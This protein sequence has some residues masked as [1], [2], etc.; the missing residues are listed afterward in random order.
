VL[1]PNGTLTGS[2]A[3]Q[4][5]RAPELVRQYPDDPRSYFA[6][7][8]ARLRANDGAGAE[9]ALRT[10]LGKDKTL[11][12]YF[13]ETLA[14]RIRG[15]LAGTLMMGGN[16]SAAREA[17]APL[18]ALPAGSPLLDTYSKQLRPTMCN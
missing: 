10:A 18:C 9:E 6:L 2:V 15:T 16:R 5:V 14:N 12:L 3:N 1:M 7:G 8:L 11:L 13:D 17:Y 4:D